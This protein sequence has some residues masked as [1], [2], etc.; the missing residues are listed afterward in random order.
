MKLLEGPVNKDTQIQIEKY[1]YEQGSSKV[2]DI[3]TAGIAVNRLNMSV[4]EYIE[5]GMY[6]IVNVL[7]KL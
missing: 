7:L 1:L 2:E 3:K 4:L 6:K 5:S